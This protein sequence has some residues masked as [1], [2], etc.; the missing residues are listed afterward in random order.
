MVE[1]PETQVSKADIKADMSLS[2]K[3]QLVANVF[4]SKEVTDAVMEKIKG[5]HPQT[6][7][8]SNV[9]ILTGDDKDKANIN[10]IGIFSTSG[11]DVAALA[12]RIAAG[13]TAIAEKPVKPLTEKRQLVAGIFASK[14][15]ADAAM[16]KIKS[17]G[18]QLQK[19]NA[20][21]ILVLAKDDKG[22]VDINIIDIGSTSGMNIAALAER[23]AEDIITVASKPVGSPAELNVQVTHLGHALNPGSVAI[24][25]FVDPQYAEKIKAGIEKA[26][27][28]FLTAEDLKRIGA[29]LGVVEGTNDLAAKAAAAPQTELQAAP[30]I[31]DW[32]E[33]YAYSLGLQAFIYGFPYVY[34]AL[35]RYKWTNLPQD[36]KRVPYAPV[37]HFWH[38]TELIDATYRDGGCPNNDTLYSIAWV[39]LSKEPVILSVP[40][41]PA[42]RY[43]TFELN[44]FT[45]D[46]FA[47]VGKRIGS[48]AGNYALIGPDW[49]GDLPRDVTAVT[50]SS[51][52]PWILILG[53]TLADSVDDLPS[54]HALQAQYR[55]TP[56]SFW[57]KPEVKLPESRNVYKPAVALAG[58][59]DPLG[60]WKT[61]NAM[62]AENSPATHHEVLLKQFETIGIGPG[63]DIEQQ[64]EVVKRA[65]QRVLG[66]GMSLLRQ[67]F[68]SGVWAKF[69]NGWRYPPSNMGRFGDEFLLR[70][71]DQSLAGIVANDPVEAVY[72]VNLTD[73]SGE[74][75]TSAH[76]YEVTFPKGHEP[77][78]DA[79]WSM[80]V[81]GTDNNLI[82]NQINRY[83]IGNRNPGVKKNEDGGTTFYFQSESPGPDKESNWLPTGNGAWF[84]IMR[85]Y[86]PH[87]EVVNAEW[88][89]P[90]I[91]RVD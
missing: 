21:N 14:A 54:V 62:L 69:V 86:I 13:L 28:Q 60:P 35:T 84:T 78:V 1:Y 5:L 45:S 42:D 33:E 2:E 32:Q 46:N 47:Y 76:R 24:G 30:V 23:I 90:P 25:L 11:G 91:V 17:L 64:P 4:A 56:L 61:L 22:K 49:H 38:A 15:S 80:T 10:I 87:P 16:E 89:C 48:R 65:L 68:M 74:P 51:P 3:L 8:A 34:N 52:T 67:Q 19:V 63:L 72:L 27:A 66:V 41:I 12:E 70:A 71:A 79:F 75:L 6:M 20:S 31:F 77:P 39:D 43:W 57:G 81:Y 7:D 88:K 40:E 83:S 85:M 26:G 50:P 82:P 9:L 58:S 59:N 37:N 44:T 36:P 55:L 18:P 53:R 73:N 29:G